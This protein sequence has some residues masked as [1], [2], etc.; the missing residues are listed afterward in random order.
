[1]SQCPLRS[2]LFLLPIS[3]RRVVAEEDVNEGPLLHVPR[4]VHL[5][6]GHTEGLYGLCLAKWTAYW[7]YHSAQAESVL[8]MGF[9]VLQMA[10]EWP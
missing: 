2:Q 4:N 3:K 6:T 9:D 7:A 10:H 1:M 8:K 5:E